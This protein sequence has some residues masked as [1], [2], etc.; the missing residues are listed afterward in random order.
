MSKL[1]ELAYKITD[2]NGCC[3]GQ[4]YEI[5]PA[6]AIDGKI[7]ICERGYHWSRNPMDAIKYH[8]LYQSR[9]WEVQPG[10]DIIEQSDKGVSSE[11]T[12]VRELSLKEWVDI[13]FKKMSVECLEKEKAS[14]RYSRQAASDPY[15]SQ[16]ASGP[17]SSQAASGR[18]SSQAAS[19]HYSR[20]AASG[21]DS[22]QAAS[23][24]YSSQAASGPDSRQA[25]SGHYSSQA[26]SGPYSRQAASG[27][28]SRCE[29]G[30]EHS[31]SAAIGRAARVKV[32]SKTS[33]L[34]ISDINNDGEVKRVIAKRPGQK[35]DRV[36]IKTDH[37]YWFE[38]GEL[39]EESDDGC[40]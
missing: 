9:F 4:K 24:R 8:D 23:G 13:C 22:R 11:I 33:W 6:P 30:G 3:R 37:W 12:F 20:Q 5:G 1:I 10:G 25:A 34:V 18:Y 26:A 35:C 29:S 16:A 21:P 38:D 17:Y 15:S 32:V 2:K 14:G 28:Y 40:A 31:I 7:K 19:G 36:T 27:N 39:H